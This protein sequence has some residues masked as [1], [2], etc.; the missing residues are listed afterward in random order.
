MQIDSKIHQVIIFLKALNLLNNLFFFLLDELKAVTVLS[1]ISVVILFLM[2]ILQTVK[3]FVN[4]S[5]LNIAIIFLSIL[6]GK[7]K[8][9]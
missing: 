6:N 8:E 4:K 9:N 5:K 3:L 1:A 2:F 7:F